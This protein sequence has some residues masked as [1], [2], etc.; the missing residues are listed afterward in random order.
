[1]SAPQDYAALLVIRHEGEWRVLAQ[2]WRRHSATAM[3]ASGGKQT[4]IETGDSVC[5]WP[6]AGLW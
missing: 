1:M 5:F 2:S 6:N 3:S 4:S